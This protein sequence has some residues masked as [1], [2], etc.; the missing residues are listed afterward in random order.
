MDTLLNLW[1]VSENM[2]ATNLGIISYLCVCVF[3][4]VCVSQGALGAAGNTGEQGLVGQ[5]VSIT[6]VLNI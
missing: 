6:D 5:R 2:C 3:V 4:C 1:S